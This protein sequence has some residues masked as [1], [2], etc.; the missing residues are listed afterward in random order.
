MRVK[1]KHYCPK[2]MS[3]N[4]KELVL[5]IICSDCG[6]VIHHDDI[7]AIF[8]AEEENL[9]RENSVEKYLLLDK[10]I[11][12]LKMFFLDHGVDRIKLKEYFDVP[13]DIEE[14]YF[15][16]YSEEEQASFKPY[17]IKPVDDLF[18]NTH[19]IRELYMT[20]AFKNDLDIYFNNLKVEGPDLYKAFEVFTIDIM[21][22]GLIVTLGNN[23][24]INPNLSDKSAYKTLCVE[25]SLNLFNNK[26][27]TLYKSITEIKNKNNPIKAEAEEYFFKG[28]CKKKE[29]NRLIDCNKFLDKLEA[30]VNTHVEFPNICKVVYKYIEEYKNLFNKKLDE[31][32]NYSGKY[33]S[34]IFYSEDIFPKVEVH[35]YDFDLIVIISLILDDFTYDLDE[36]IRM[37]EDEEF[38]DC[39]M[40]SAEDLEI[41]VRLL[42]VAL[43][44]NN[45]QIEDYI[46]SLHG[47]EY[48]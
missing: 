26:T 6:E 13:K 44:K 41:A 42:G 22:Y 2:C 10:L 8:A 31:F 40:Y 24:I 37:L 30:I 11:S 36:A 20:I 1:M 33:Y 9:E 27:A 46:Y 18:F 5:N 25:L 29:I 39:P 16:Y 4:L 35:F 7:E 3:Y 12:I 28:L 21:N 19:S 43:T 34:Y 15:Y 47:K 48:R 23:K 14:D 45:P 17:R 38:G 32:C